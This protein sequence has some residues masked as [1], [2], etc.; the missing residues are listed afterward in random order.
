MSWD[1][2]V[3][4]ALDVSRGLEYLHDGVS[5][6]HLHQIWDCWVLCTFVQYLFMHIVL[7]ILCFS[8][9]AVPPVIHRDIKSSNILLDQSMRARVCS[10]IKAVSKILLTFFIA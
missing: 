8:I 9:Q 5:K 1:L 3:N 7:I 10:S 4:I 2:R 6:S